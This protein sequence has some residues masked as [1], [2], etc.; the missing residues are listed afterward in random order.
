MSDKRSRL[1]LARLPAPATALSHSS[2]IN[3]A[4][5]L[6]IALVYHGT[7]ALYSLSL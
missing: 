3:G 5:Y 1:A 2:V 4:M 7:V 6:N